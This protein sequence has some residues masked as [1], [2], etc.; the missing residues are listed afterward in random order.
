MYGKPE[1]I[2]ELKR[3]TEVEDGAISQ[4]TKYPISEQI[5]R[6]QTYQLC[7]SSKYCAEKRKYILDGIK[8][9]SRLHFEQMCTNLVIHVLKNP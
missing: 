9:E 7:A 6:K 3:M 8:E 2:I 4:G 5:T 1:K